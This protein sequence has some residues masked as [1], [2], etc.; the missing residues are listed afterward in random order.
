MLLAFATFPF[1]PTV[2][3]DRKRKAVLTKVAAG[4]ACNATPGGSVTVV[5]ELAGTACFLRRTDH[6]V[7]RQAGR[8]HHRRR[9]STLDEWSVDEP[10]VSVGLTFEHVA[11]GEHSAAKI[12][13]NNYA[14]AAVGAQNR[15]SHCV[16]VGT[17]RASRT[18]AGRLDPDL[19]PGN[20][21][22]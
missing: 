16:A 5:S 11:Y 18:A 20:L 21:R 9:N 15:L 7:K 6:I 2:T 10:D 1:E 17:Q 12:R 19:G 4:R 8:R 3:L 22:G 13:Q 14:L